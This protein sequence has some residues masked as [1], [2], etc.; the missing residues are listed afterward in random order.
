MDKRH[1]T[2]A[3]LA[4]ACGCSLQNIAQIFNGRTGLRFDTA[5]KLCRS[6]GLRIVLSLNEEPQ[7]DLEHE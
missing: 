4:R 2:E 7:P 6:T 3:D 5:E 1:I